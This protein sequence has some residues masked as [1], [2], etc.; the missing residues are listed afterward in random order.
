L[1]DILHRLDAPS[2]RQLNQDTGHN[3]G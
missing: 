3:A 1:G 2:L